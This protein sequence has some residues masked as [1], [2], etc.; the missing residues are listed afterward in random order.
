MKIYKEI[1]NFS[2]EDLDS[3]LIEQ[4]K[5]LLT[6][7]KSHNAS[8]LDNP[9]EIRNVRRQIA[10]LHTE[11]RKRQIEKTENNES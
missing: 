3:R 5:R 11:I 10:R 8:P 2:D 4:E 1:K 6:L 9:L 7:K